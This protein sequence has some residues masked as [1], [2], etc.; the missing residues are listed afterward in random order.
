VCPLHGPIELVHQ[1]ES[2]TG[3][4]SWALEGGPLELAVA[5]AGVDVWE[6]EFQTDTEVWSELTLAL[7][8][9]QPGSQAPTRQQWRVRFLHPKD[10]SRLN[11][12][13]EGMMAGGRPYEMAYRIWLEDDGA[14]RWL[15]SRALIRTAPAVLRDRVRP[16]T[17]PP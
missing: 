15:Y 8:G 10:L 2:L 4:G 14:L 12:R 7:Y 3:I 5:A 13:A 1:A 16:A 9:L 11:A 17:S 6:T